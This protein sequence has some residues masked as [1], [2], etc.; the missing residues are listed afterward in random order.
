MSKEFELDNKNLLTYFGWGGLYTIIELFS[1]GNLGLFSIFLLFIINGFVILTIETFLGKIL[2][3]NSWWKQSF[4]VNRVTCKCGSC[5]DWR[6]KNTL[7][8]VIIRVLLVFPICWIVLKISPFLVGN[9]SIALEA[10]ILEKKLGKGIVTSV[11]SVIKIQ[12]DEFVKGKKGD[13]YKVELNS[14][15]VKE[16]VL[17]PTGRYVI[18]DLDN[19]LL[20]P[21]NKFMNEVYETIESGKK[22]DLFVRGNADLLGNET[23]QGNFENNYEIKEG[24]SQFSI[25]P[26]D[27]RYYSSIPQLIK[28]NEPFRNSDLPD[29]RGR[30]LQKKI[31]DNHSNLKMPKILEG[32]VINRV[33]FEDRSGYLIMYV[34]WDSNGFSWIPDWLMN[35]IM[36]LISFFSLK[37][38]L[39]PKKWLDLIINVK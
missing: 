1:I 32:K 24:F 11:F 33:S 10:K 37:I 14:P 23:F 27:G 38:K 19:R 30:F 31:Y 7:K 26:Y 16:K 28:I 17:F 12:N 35:V 15:D 13:Y 29:L 25:H 21:V 22:A 5:Y 8:Q 6:K 3:G 2:Y 18:D 4:F 36:F 39:K 9:M 20:I 34:D